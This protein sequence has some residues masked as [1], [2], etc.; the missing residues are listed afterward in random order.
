MKQ[1]VFIIMALVLTLFSA[2]AQND[3]TIDQIG[4][5]SVMEDAVEQTI[6]LTGITDGDGGQP[7]SISV[8]SDNPSLFSTLEIATG[9]A[10]TTLVY[11]TAPDA[12]GSAVVTISV[13]DADGTTDMAFTITVTPI[14]DPP[15]IDPHA[16]V[17]VNEDAGTIHV[18]LT[19][20]SGGPADEDQGLGFTMY[21]SN[22]IVV[23]SMYINYATGDPEATLDITINPDSA[24]VSNIQIQVI[25]EL[26]SNL[27]TIKFDLFV[28]PVNDEPTFET[29]D[30]EVILNDGVEH[31]IPLAGISEGPGNEADQTLTF[32]ITNDNNTLL[33][34][35]SIDYT[36]GSAT[37][38]LRYT[39]AAG[40]EGVANITVRLSDDGGTLNGGSDYLEHTFKIIINNTVTLVTPLK[41]SSL[42][43]Y[44]NPVSN[45]L[46]IT[47]PKSVSGASVIEIYSASGEK[48]LSNTG[49]GRSLQVTVS[50]LPTGWYQIKVTSE[51]STYT[52]NFLVK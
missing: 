34:N 15:T 19:G 3:P 41:E 43:L 7:T 28:L 16:D 27:V 39:P 30:D 47:L 21:S 38:V 8:V 1:S 17:T 51:E 10:D 14:N 32:D 37:G 33:S 6:L 22:P 24:G 49:S 31:T 44:P 2:K 36:E 46:K 13:T 12:N 35:L 50:S 52:G 23:D 4:N 11:Q 45:L 26:Y 29:I 18:T 5:Q 40:E 42:L 48:V 9:T 25:D 20:I